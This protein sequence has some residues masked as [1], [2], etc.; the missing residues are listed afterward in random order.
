[1]SLEMA[2]S[3]VSSASDD[4]IVQTPLRKRERLLDSRLSPEEKAAHDAMVETMG[5]GAIWSRWREA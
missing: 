2:P 1:M 3:E 4:M 5:D